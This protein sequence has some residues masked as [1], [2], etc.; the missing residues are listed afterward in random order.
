VKYG[1]LSNDT[2]RVSLSWVVEPPDGT[3]PGGRCCFT[4]KEQGGPPAEPP[5]T[6]GF[7]SQLV[8]RS[9]GGKPATFDFR[10]SGLVCT[11]EAPL[12][13][14]EPAQEKAGEGSPAPA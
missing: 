8:E 10:P 13:L 7:G 9:L 4:W 11:F 3:A 2:G 12:P 5:A 6:R 14:H 1:A